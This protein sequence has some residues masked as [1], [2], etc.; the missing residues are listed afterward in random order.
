MP[1]IKI[2]TNS[3][4]R[5]TEAEKPTGT[6]PQTDAPQDGATLQQSGAVI[7][8]TRTIAA[9]TTTAADTNGPPP[10]QPGARPI[11]PSQYIPQASNAI[12]SLAAAQP[13]AVPT[14]NHITTHE[15][16]LPHA[17]PPQY[18]IPAPIEPFLP[19]KST[20]THAIPPPPRAGETT[21]MPFPAFQDGATV[22]Q[23]Y[24]SP[25]ETV[26]QRAYG[27]EQ[28][29]SLDHPRNYVQNPY[30]DGTALDRE[31]KTSLIQEEQAEE[32]VL[33]N[34][35]RALGGVGEKLQQAEEQAWKW[36]QGKP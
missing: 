22:A 10:P 3:P 6:T 15:T 26:G 27:Q 7:T 14:V 19:T 29:T 35:K 1:P 13:G 16:R 32:G 5:P 21:T 17:P 30:A 28:N 2:H 9:T 18:S 11:A 36:A 24:T 33:G 20:A 8:P 12:S 31:R 23:P 4:L 25:A 34:V